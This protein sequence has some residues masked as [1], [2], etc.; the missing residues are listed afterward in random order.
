MNPV[1]VEAV[2]HSVCV[3]MLPAGIIVA[4]AVAGIGLAIKTIVSLVT[5]IAVSLAVRH[6]VLS[7]VLASGVSIHALLPGG[8]PAFIVAGIETVLRLVGL[9]GLA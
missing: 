8:L 5:G 2:G 9:G 3:G 1:C 4:I 6:T 7:L